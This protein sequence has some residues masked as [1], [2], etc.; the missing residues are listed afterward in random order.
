VEASSTIDRIVSMLPAHEIRIAYP[1]KVTLIAESMKK[2]DENDTHI[3]LDLYNKSYMPESYL[4]PADI[5]EARNLCR[6]CYFLIGQ[7]TAVKN[8][9]RDQSAEE[10]WCFTLLGFALKNISEMP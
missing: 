6:N 2:T 7:R 9:I 1:M 5:R 8:R 10:L 3:L 4:H